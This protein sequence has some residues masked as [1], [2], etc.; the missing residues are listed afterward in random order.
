MTKNST[1]NPQKT[2]IVKSD[3]VRAVSVK[4]SLSVAQAEKAVDAF[5]AAMADG[6]AQNRRVELRGFGS[7]KVRTHNGYLGRNPKTGDTVSVPPKL[8]P[9]FRAGKDI[10]LAINE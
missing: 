8:L 5:F 10:K 3:I 7:F 4:M 6:L 9:H 1:S 2:D